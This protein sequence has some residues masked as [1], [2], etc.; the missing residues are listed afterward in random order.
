MC[1]PAFKKVLPPV[2]VAI[3]HLRRNELLKDNSE[4]FGSLIVLHF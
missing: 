4:K 1:S 2:W 3:D